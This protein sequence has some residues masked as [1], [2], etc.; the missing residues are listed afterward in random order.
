MGRGTYKKCVGGWIQNRGLYMGTTSCLKHPPRL[1]WREAVPPVLQGYLQMAGLNSS[2]ISQQTVASS[3]SWMA[4]L[5]WTS[6]SIF[7]QD[8]L[9]SSYIPKHNDMVGMD[10]MTVTQQNGWPLLCGNVSNHATMG[11]LI[12][13]VCIH[14]LESVC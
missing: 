9:D 5:F 3:P 6:R 13:I 1:V 8:G 14:S 7:Y 10:S 4:W 2:F 12:N 11:L